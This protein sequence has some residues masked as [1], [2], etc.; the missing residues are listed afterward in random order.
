MVLCERLMARLREVEHPVGKTSVTVTVSLGLA[1]HTADA[2]FQSASDLIAAAD[3]CVYAAK[4]VGRDQLV[5]HQAH[6]L[7]QTG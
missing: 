5:V 7:G 4:R 6:R 2:P 1:T 3:G